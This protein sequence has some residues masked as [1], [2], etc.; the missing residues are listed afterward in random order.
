[1][2]LT[3]RRSA[4][5]TSKYLT[6]AGMF[7]SVHTAW[8]SHVAP[9][10]GVTCF[11]FSNLA[12]GTTYNVGQVAVFPDITAEV[13]PLYTLAGVP[14]INAA[15]KAS[16]AGSRIAGSTAPEMH[17]YYTNM[18][19]TPTLPVAEISMHFAQ[20]TGVN[21][22]ALISNLEVNGEKVQLENGMASAHGMVLGN[23][24]VGQVQITST[25]TNPVP[26]NA[27]QWISGELEFTA[28]SGA[29]ESIT[30][31]SYTAMFDDV[32]LIQ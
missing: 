20:N 6:L 14:I 28:L 13:L 11:D 22:F 4:A 30:I 3:N 19:M 5:P 9:G 1:M 24:A 2:K 21:N 18:R 29:I 27:A 15:Q 10:P 32:C 26:P 16:V 8:A 31:G 7:L 23:N 25:L 17:L 12:V